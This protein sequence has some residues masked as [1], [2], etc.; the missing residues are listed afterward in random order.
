[1]PEPTPKDCAL[2]LEEYQFLTPAQAQELRKLLPRFPQ[3][4][5]L[6]KELRR[7]GW[8]TAYQGNQLF[9]GNGNDLVL[10]PYRLLEQIGEGGM[11]R[12]FKAQHVRMDRLVA[13]KVIHQ[14]NL[15]GPRAVER[16]NREARAA[17][18]LSYPNIVL[19]HDSDTVE[20]RHFLAMEYVEGTD[21][22]KR[23]PRQFQ[24][25]RRR[26]AV[27]LD[28]LP[29]HRVSTLV[30]VGWQDAVRPVSAARQ[31]LV[32]APCLAGADGPQAQQRPEPV[33]LIP[34]LR[35]VAVVAAFQVAQ[36]FVLPLVVR[37]VQEHVRKQ[38]E[39][40]LGVFVAGTDSKDASQ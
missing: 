19:V 39:P 22:A 11:S 36:G 34:E 25:N 37:L 35:A 10:G 28:H 5:S 40:A 24:G 27:L 7:R 18:Q 3:V 12:V 1:M 9:Q 15:T 8:L 23:V 20:G 26:L 38:E 14:Q 32:L 30:I 33:A 4:A 17:A 2:F 13:L 16:F 21:L 31:R 29:L 6:V